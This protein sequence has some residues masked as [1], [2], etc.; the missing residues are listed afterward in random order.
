M[1]DLLTTRQLAQYL[2]L[3]ER[4]V[5]RML[6][7]GELPATRVGGQWR[8]RKSAVDE[9]LDQGG[10]ALAGDDSAAGSSAAATPAA[11]ADAQQFGVADRLSANNIML[12]LA[13]GSPSEVLAEL[14]ARLQLPEPADRGLLLARLLERESLCS[15]AVAD[16]IA[17]PHTPR[18]RPRVLRHHDV[19]AIARTTSPVAFGAL[20]GNPTSVFVLVLAADERAHL[21]LLAKMARLVREPVVRTALRTGDAATIR[22]VLRQTESSLFQAVAV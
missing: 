9:W 10:M 19:L 12:D 21:T 7:R 16:G 18:T 5:Y 11:A 8:F 13:P 22:A 17:V 14:V 20:D 4:S 2:Q 1:P 3:S 6:E 15:T